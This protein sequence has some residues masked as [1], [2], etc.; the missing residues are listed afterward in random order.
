MHT[1]T[2][3][4]KNAQQI[5]TVV[6]ELKAHGFVANEH[7]QFKYIPSSWNST[8][9]KIPAKTEFTFKEDKIATWFVLKWS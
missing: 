3:E 8:D 4:G 7:Y 9:G 5:S 1:I 2:L 6:S